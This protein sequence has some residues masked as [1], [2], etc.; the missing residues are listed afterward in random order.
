MCLDNLFLSKVVNLACEQTSQT[1]A[2]K[3]MVPRWH[4][5]LHEESLTFTEPYYYYYTNHSIQW[6]K[7][8]CRLLKSMEQNGLRG[9]ENIVPEMLCV[10]PK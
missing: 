8:L 10:E 6:K 9:F 1:L 2:S 7:V 5:W 3:S 4:Q